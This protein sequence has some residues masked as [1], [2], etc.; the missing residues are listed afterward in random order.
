MAEDVARP[1][2]EY[3]CKSTAQTGRAEGFK[4]S[5]IKIV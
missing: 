3:K 4:T 5:G 2:V 1:E